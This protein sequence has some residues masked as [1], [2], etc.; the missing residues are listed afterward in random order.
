M[1]QLQVIPTPF[2][3]GTEAATG[4]AD[5]HGVV[6][7]S[8]ASGARRIVPIRALRLKSVVSDHRRIKN[9]QYG[10][11]RKRASGMN[12]LSVKYHFYDAPPQLF[13][14]ERR[15]DYELWVSWPL[16]YVLPSDGRQSSRRCRRGMMFV[17]AKPSVA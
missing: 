1:Q 10:N 5:G 17:A 12:G 9:A 13:Q 7:G 15:D 8:A 4:T 3:F 14:I 2:S 16:A 11:E 6:S